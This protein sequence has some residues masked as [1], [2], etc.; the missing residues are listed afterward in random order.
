[1]ESTSL[2]TEEIITEPQPKSGDTS[3]FSLAHLTSS[4][5]MMNEIFDYLPGGTIIHKIALL[6][7]RIRQGLTDL[8]PFGKARIIKLKINDGYF[9][10]F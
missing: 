1:M 2:Q 3:A 10:S 9:F 5:N 4:K 8:D 6:N 7:K